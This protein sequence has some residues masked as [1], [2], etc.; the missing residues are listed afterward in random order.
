MVYLGKQI[1]TSNMLQKR[2]VGVEEKRR[3]LG[4]LRCER[5]TL[6]LDNLMS[7]MFC[8]VRTSFSLY[9]CT[10]MHI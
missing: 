6:V 8:A 5:S 3:R 2:A 4:R 7:F 10:L 1:K 9:L